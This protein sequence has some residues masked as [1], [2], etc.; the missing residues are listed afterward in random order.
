MKSEDSA[1][2]CCRVAILFPIAWTIL[3]IC[4][5]PAF[6]VMFVGFRVAISAISIMAFVVLARSLRGW[7]HVFALPVWLL[8]AFA[9]YVTWTFPNWTMDDWER[10]RDNN[11]SRMKFRTLPLPATHTPPKGDK[12]P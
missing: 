2:P 6:P 5:L 7:R 11:S 9:I 12:N 4:L 3:L 10:A 8:L 1:T